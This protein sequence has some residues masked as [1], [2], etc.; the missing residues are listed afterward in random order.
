MGARGRLDLR[1]LQHQRLVDV[2]AAGCVVHDDVVALQAR[3]LLGA[4]GDLHG[5]LAGDD[6]QRVDADLTAE[7]GE[8]LLRGGTLHV[9]RGHEHLALHAVA[10]TLGDLGG[11]GGLARALQADHHD[12]DGR[13]GVEIDGIGGGAERLDQHIVDDLDDHLTG[14]DRLDHIRAD[15]AAAHLVDEGTHDIEGDVRLQQ[16]APDLAERHVDVR[17]AQG[18]AAPELVENA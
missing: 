13:R 15:G 17:L 8:L 16:G 7:H 18:A 11:G 1:H 14:R 10:Q 6:G 4:A 3:G 12:C 2:G 9:E 5:R